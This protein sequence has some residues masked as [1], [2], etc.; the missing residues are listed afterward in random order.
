MVFFATAN[1]VNLYSPGWCAHFGFPL[2]YQGWSDAQLVMN[3]VNYGITP[4][5]PTILAVN[6]VVGV[7]FSSVVF[8]LFRRR[9]HVPAV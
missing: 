2:E 3:G 8:V 9:V 1:L 5:N 7:A 4:F 6:A